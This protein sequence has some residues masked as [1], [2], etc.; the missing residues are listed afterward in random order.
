MQR[1]FRR[2]QLAALNLPTSGVRLLRIAHDDWCSFVV[3]GVCNCS[4]D[5]TLE[6]FSVEALAASRER[7]AAWRRERLS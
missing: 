5:Q 1:R 2:A 7:L 4:P 3:S 6:P